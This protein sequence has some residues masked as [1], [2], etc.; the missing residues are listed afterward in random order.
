MQAADYIATSGNPVIYFA[1]EMSEI[2]LIG[3]SIS[4]RTLH[5]ALESKNMNLAKTELGITDGNRYGSYSESELDIIRAAWEEYK[6]EEGENLIFYSGGRTIDEIKKITDEYIS[7]T[8]KTP[9]VFID[10]LQLLK[11][12]DDMK[13]AQIR[14]QVNYNIRGIMDMKRELQTPLVVISSFN[15][16][17]YTATADNSSFKESGEIEY[18]ADCTIT[19]EVDDIKGEAGSN[20]ARQ[21]FIAGMRRDT[22]NLKLTF[23]KNRSGR[24]GSTIYLKYLPKFNL[25]EEDQDRSEY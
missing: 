21:S 7:F 11:P 13:R 8:G 14:E 16:G 20:E 10:Y 5:K 24:V 17:S 4:R 9:V 3:R 6:T 2:E 12:N 1:L 18:T 25:F 22:R 15:R 23:Q 19:L